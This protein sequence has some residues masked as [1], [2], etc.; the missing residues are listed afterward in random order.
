MLVEFDLR[1]GVNENAAV[2]YELSKKAK[3]K[4]GGLG[5]GIEAIESKIAREK[6]G[7]QKHAA[8]LSRKRERKWYEKFHWF[9][10]REGFLVISGR[11]AKGN[12]IAVNRH[13]G[14][15]DLYFHADIQGAAHT[16]L[17]SE[18]RVPGEQSRNEAAVF[19][20][21]FSKAW[22]FGLPA[23]DVYSVLPGQVSK[24]APSGE[25]IGTGAFMVRGERRWY[26]KTRLEFAIGFRSE[27]DYYAVFSGPPSAVKK[28]A[29]F[30]LAISIGSMQKGDAAKKVLSLFRQKAGKGATF[31]LDDIVA[32]LPGGGMSINL[33]AAHQ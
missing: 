3:K 33:H 6:A 26:R 20:A 8:A 14:E 23:V 19:A 27:G 12:E 9:F 24:S 25:S 4:L 7:A 13:M 28:T 17:K 18:G 32:L 5:R 30:S 2:Y 1:K 16:I 10:T 29:E 11:D 31:S 22:Q 15:G 21:V